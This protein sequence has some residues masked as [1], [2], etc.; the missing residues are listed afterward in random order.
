MK[1]HR[2]LLF[3]AYLFTGLITVGPPL[4]AQG[5]AQDRSENDKVHLISAQVAEM[6]ELFGSQ[7]PQSH[8][9]GQFSS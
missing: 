6:Y 7:L 3:F 2:I 4:L 9:S 1:R 5:S 8:R